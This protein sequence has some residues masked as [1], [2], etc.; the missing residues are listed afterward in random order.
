MV[1]HALFYMFVCLLF[2]VFP[3]FTVFLGLN[4]EFHS[5]KRERFLDVQEGR[6]FLVS[7]MPILSMYT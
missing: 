5:A 1:K 2:V 6:D 7:F 4:S 3:Q